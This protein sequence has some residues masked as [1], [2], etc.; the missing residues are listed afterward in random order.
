MPQSTLAECL[1]SLKDLIG[2]LDSKLESHNAAQALL[3]LLLRTDALIIPK[4]LLLSLLLELNERVICAGELNE[5]ALDVAIR[6]ERQLSAIA[7]D[8]G[9]AQGC[10]EVTKH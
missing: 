4:D 1:A 10:G 9:S 8:L 7:D 5:A 6:A 3:W 2:L